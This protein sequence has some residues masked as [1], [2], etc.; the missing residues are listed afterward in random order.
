MEIVADNFRQPWVHRA[1]NAGT[2]SSTIA[3]ALVIFSA[4]TALAGTKNKF[5]GTDLTS[6]SGYAVTPSSSTDVLLGTA[7]AS[8][9][10]ITDNGSVTIESLNVTSNSPGTSYVV[11]NTNTNAT[12]ST[13]TLGNSAGFTN[14]YSG[15]TNDLLYATTSSLTIAGP[16]NSTGTGALGIV[17]ASSGNFDA[18]GSSYTIL[19]TAAISGAGMS[20][21]S[22]GSGTVEL[23]GRGTF[24]GT[25]TQSGTGSTVIGDG[26][27]S[28]V[29]AV[30]V[31]AGTL[32]TF[33][34]QTNTINDAASVTLSGGTIDFSA[35]SE[36]IG[37]LAG[38]SSSAVLNIGD[39]TS[40]SSATPPNTLYAGTFTVGYN[41]ATT[42]FA[43]KIT[44]THAGTDAIFTKIGTGILTLSG[45]NTYTGATA[46]T[47]GGIV[48]SNAAGLGAT[49]AGNGT[50]VSSGAGLGLS[51]GIAV[52]AE[53]LTL[54]GTGI[55]ANPT[56]ALRNI[57]GANSFAGAI[58]LG[59]GSTITTSVGTLTLTGGITNG[60]NLLTFDG[61]GNTAVSTA[62]ITGAGG[63]TKNGAGTLT[64]T[65]G[66][67]YTGA[68]TV[69]NGTLSAG[70]ASGSQALG[71]TT[72]INVNTGGTLLF[73]TANQANNAAPVT[74]GGGTIQKAAGASQGAANS[75]GF[76]ALTLNASSTLNYTQ[77]DGTL[78]FAS[79]TPGG[80]VLTI[81]NYVGNGTN[82]GAEHLIFDEDESAKLDYF[83]FGQGTGSGFVGQAN[84]GNG[85]YEIYSLVP[86][87]EPATWFG[88][89][90]LL[91]AA[92]WSQRRRW[93]AHARLE[94]VA[95]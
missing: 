13:L 70:A 66:N 84:L 95:V 7:S 23:E 75:V 18:V 62:A 52:G 83:N 5:T 81:A 74:L 67:T 82:N 68:T 17:L 90:L 50:V 45:A 64:L 12:N 36:T 78:T 65:V 57:S 72:Q 79:F 37:S 86:V 56:G 59:S 85:F 15:F 76:G 41:N 44:G 38:T 73:A 91:G 32:E 4:A 60:G 24:S 21:T 58:T 46:I 87:P 14:A 16:N 61:A 92:G 6:S 88:G 31:S 93:N 27:L 35:G 2:G 55:A 28:A 48:I 63:L 39:Y 47:A 49:G 80:N 69:N 43:G 20:L 30:T 19:V 71:G 53:A 25:F 29:T 8:Q 77:T 34:S 33:L 11:S 40:S 26:A 10:L 89:L 42:S 54:N 3:V 94:A 51:G 1:W 22:N 9:A